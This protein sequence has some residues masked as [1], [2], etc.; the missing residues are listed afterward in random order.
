M[1]KVY[2]CTNCRRVFY[3]QYENNTECRACG[4]EMQKSRLSFIQYT[5]LSPIRRKIEIRN[6][7]W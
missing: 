1:L 3:I 6:E 4:R 5:S 2:Y 7:F